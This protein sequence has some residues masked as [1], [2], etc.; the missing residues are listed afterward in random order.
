MEK[1][2]VGQRYKIDSVTTAEFVETR[3]KKNLGTP[4]LHTL[5]TCNRQRVPVTSQ[6]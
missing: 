5:K 1:L 2:I 6:M 3:K 4:M